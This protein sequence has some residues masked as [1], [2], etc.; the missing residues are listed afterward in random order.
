[1]I[2]H[3]PQKRGDQILKGLRLHPPQVLLDLAPGLL[4]GLLEGDLDRPFLAGLPCLLEDGLSF[5]STA[6]LPPPVIEVRG[7]ANELVGLLIGL[8]G[9]LSFVGYPDNH[10]SKR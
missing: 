5:G 2:A 1:V 4:L 10:Q 8:Q 7:S 6:D 9:P 3:A